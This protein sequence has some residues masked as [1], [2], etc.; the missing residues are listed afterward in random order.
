MK[1][2]I[3]EYLK[4]GKKNILLIY[5]LFLIGLIIPALLVIG[6][7]LAFIKKN[8]ENTIWQGHYI[9]AF[10]TF[11]FPF[12]TFICI[13]LLYLGVH[14]FILMAFLGGGVM[15]LEALPGLES[16][17]TNI[18]IAIRIWIFVRIIVA[19]K[20]ILANKQHPKAPSS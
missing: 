20:L 6:G 4:A 9:F 17:Y 12:I 3:N 2:T 8:T 19:I 15:A 13:T 5:V 1:D 14:S 10:R 16:M 18:C 11:I 7:I